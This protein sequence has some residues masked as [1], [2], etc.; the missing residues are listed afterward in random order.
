MLTEAQITDQGLVPLMKLPLNYL[1]V[2]GT[3]VTDAVIPILKT[4]PTLTNVPVGE[5]KMTAAGKAELQ[6]VLEANRGR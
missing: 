4:C 3:P 5:T 2:D 1:R 6:R